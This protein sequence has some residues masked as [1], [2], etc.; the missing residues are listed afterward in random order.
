MA[1][2]KTKTETAQVLVGHALQQA[3]LDVVTN[4]KEYI[5]LI[6]PFVE[7]WRDL[8]DALAAAKDRGVDTLLLTESPRRKRKDPL[9]AFVD[10][11]GV[12][13]RQVESVHAK[14]YLNEGV[15]LVSSFNLLDAR[16]EPTD[17]GVLLH[18][19]KA[20]DDLLDWVEGLEDGSA[21]LR[22][23][24]PDRGDSRRRGSRGGGRGG[25]RGGNRGGSRDDDRGN[26]RSND[27]DG[28]RNESRSAGGRSRN[29]RG[30]FCI[31]CGQENDRVT[32]PR[33]FCDACFDDSDRG[34]DLNA[35][36]EPSCLG[37]G[38]GYDSSPER[39]F[40]SDCFR[41]RRR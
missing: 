40:C 22:Y 3:V 12:R 11:S 31:G 17:V 41:N 7:H 38:K 28:D 37:C 2:E 9:R 15:A 19:D 25:D 29:E 24:R 35:V 4:A 20:H 36:P 16:R 8:S 6:C 13:A 18:S 5:V 10:E 14:V 33:P 26:D 21:E 30:G 39:P 32:P 23:D 27:R 1:N 34:R